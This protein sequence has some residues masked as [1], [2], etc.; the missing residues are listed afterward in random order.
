MTCLIC[1][2]QGSGAYLYEHGR[3]KHGQNLGVRVMTALHRRLLDVSE[4]DD[5]QDGQVAGHVLHR[6]RADLDS[7]DDEHEL[8]GPALLRPQEHGLLEPE[9]VPQQDRDEDEGHHRASPEIQQDIERSVEKELCDLLSFLEIVKGVPESTVNRIMDTLN[10]MASYGQQADPCGNPLRAVLAKVDLDTAKKRQKMFQGRLGPPCGR[11]IWIPGMRSERANAYFKP[12]SAHLKELLQCDEVVESLQDRNVREL[13]DFS[14][15]YREHEEFIHDFESSVRFQAISDDLG[16]EPFIGLRIFGDGFSP[17]QIGAHRMDNSELYGIYFQLTSF[18]AHLCRA[19]KAWRTILLADCREVSN[20]RQIWANVVADIE[21]LQAD[22]IFVPQL[23]RKVKVLLVSYCGDLKDQNE[24]CAVAPPGSSRFPHATSLVSALARR[25]CQTFADI[26]PLTQRRNRVDHERDIDTFQRT[27]SL[28]LSRGAKDHS[29]LDSVV[30]FIEH[31][32]F[33]TADISHSFYLGCGREDLALALSV[34]VAMGVLLEDEIDDFMTSFKTNLSGEDRANFTVNLFGTIKVFRLPVKGSI[35]QCRLLI[36]YCTIIFRH[37]A[38]STE[39]DAILHRAWGLIVGVHKFHL[40]IESYA[41][42]KTQIQEFQSH[43]EDYINLRIKVRDDYE[44]LTGAKVDILPKHVDMMGAS[45]DFEATGSLI[46]SST[47]VME[48][49]NGL[50]KQVL[51]KSKNR[52]NC[53]ATLALRTE[54]LEKYQMDTLLQDEDMVGKRFGV[55]AAGSTL[56]VEQRQEILRQCG[57]DFCQDLEIHG[58]VIRAGN[59]VEIYEDESC[60]NSRMVKVLGVDL[61]DREYVCF[62]CENFSSEFIEDYNCFGAKD[63]QKNVVSVPVEEL[64]NPIGYTLIPV[65][66]LP[67]DYLFTRSQMIPIK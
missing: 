36:K 10:V 18:P 63:F 41:L 57:H 47:T 2:K 24:L 26:N 37:L 44:G 51:Q 34:F 45:A 59:I 4:D 13:R 6:E 62:L 46:L 32:G 23:N 15:W 9:E 3:R 1:G 8:P 50:H 27:R 64:C 52:K 20:T 67:Y 30:D 43:I 58:R 38:D 16:G 56:T 54:L 35:S 5:D 21:L 61:T 48:S 29:V 19:V 25:G 33:L 12:I 53:I 39:E 49:R 65:T 55:P 14:P 28:I 11:V 31:R 7:E 22:G 40:Y 66:E 17:N 60:T 42:S